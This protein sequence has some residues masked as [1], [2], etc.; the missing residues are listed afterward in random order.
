MKCWLVCHLIML[1]K[2]KFYFNFRDELFDNIMNEKLEFPTE[3]SKEAK[4]LLR[5][6]S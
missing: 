3:V 6:V 2:S 5:R 4:D 1:T